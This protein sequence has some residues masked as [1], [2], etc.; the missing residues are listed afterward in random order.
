MHTSVFV[1]FE[2][3]PIFNKGVEIVPLHLYIQSCV[4]LNNSAKIREGA[5]PGELTFLLKDQDLDRSDNFCV[6][7]W[8]ICNLFK[9]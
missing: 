1:S 5:F 6:F 8:V 7:C 9:S 3:Y 4:I 2:T